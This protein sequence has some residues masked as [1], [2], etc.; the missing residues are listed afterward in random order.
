MII[1]P[2]EAAWAPRSST[3]AA[4]AEGSQAEPLPDLPQAPTPACL[5]TGGFSGLMTLGPVPQRGPSV[6]P[7]NS[8][9]RLSQKC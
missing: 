1:Q 2:D 8:E 4:G 3:E 7:L 5:I 6:I 9:T